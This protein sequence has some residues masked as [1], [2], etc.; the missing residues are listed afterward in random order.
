MDRFR[1]AFEDCQLHDLGFEGDIFTWRN[2]IHK[3]ENYIRERHDRAVANDLRRRHFPTA[4]VIHGDPRHS[5]HRPLIIVTDRPSYVQ[6]GIRTRKSFCFEASW[7]GGRSAQR[8]WRIPRRKRW[9][10]GQPLFMRRSR[11]WRGV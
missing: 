4:C 8:W 7:L 10:G 2:H 1:E 3:A 11:L 6:H 9:K 5:D